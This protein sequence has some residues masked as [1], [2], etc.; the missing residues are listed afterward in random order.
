MARYIASLVELKLRTEP[1]GGAAADGRATDR[2]KS[3]AE[4]YPSTVTSQLDVATVRT[5]KS[6][7]VVPDLVDTLDA[8]TAGSGGL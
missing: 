8:Q 5:S 2:I 6:A 4:R 7:A 1:I 3:V